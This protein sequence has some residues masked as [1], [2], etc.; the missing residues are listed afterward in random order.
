MQ[1][2]EGVFVPVWKEVAEAVNTI[3]DRV[4]FKD[5]VISGEQILR[6]PIEDFMI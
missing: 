4:T 2:P 5:L 1:W 3:Y 6:G